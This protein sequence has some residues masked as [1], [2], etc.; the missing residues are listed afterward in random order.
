MKKEVIESL[1]SAC[2]NGKVCEKNKN[3]L[4]RASDEQCGRKVSAGMVRCGGG[5]RKYC[6]EDR[7]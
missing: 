4:W 2:E 6:V 3:C 5:M 7:I 1:E